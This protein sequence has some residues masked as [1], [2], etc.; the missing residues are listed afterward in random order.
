MSILNSKF[1][2]IWHQWEWFWCE[3]KLYYLNSES[4][5]TGACPENFAGP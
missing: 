2:F 3:I 5:D 4:P 1:R